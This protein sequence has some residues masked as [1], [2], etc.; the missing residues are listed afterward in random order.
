MKFRVQ[1]VG[2]PVWVRS[3]RLMSGDPLQWAPGYVGP[4]QHES[5]GFVR[6]RELQFSGFR[7]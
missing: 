3:H 6:A 1:S 7:G 4:V 5:L 2:F